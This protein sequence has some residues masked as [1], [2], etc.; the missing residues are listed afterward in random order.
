MK[1]NWGAWV[2]GLVAAVIQ[3]GSN[4]V[5]ASV[6]V[7]M[8]APDKFNLT[9]QLHNFLLLAGVT[10]VMSGGMGFFSYLAKHPTP[11]REV[12]TDEQRAA[13]TNGKDTK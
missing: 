7:N 12:W 6:A 10:F 13:K 4:A 2:L 3:G 8:I 11:D 5:V 9:G 1:L